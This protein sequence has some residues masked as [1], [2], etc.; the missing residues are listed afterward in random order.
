LCISECEPVHA[1]PGPG[2]DGADQ[3]T[4]WRS[5]LVERIHQD[6][7]GDLG[8]LL[9]ERDDLLDAGP[10]AGQRHAHR[11]AQGGA[12]ADEQLDERRDHRTQSGEGRGQALH[13]P[14]D[15]AVPGQAGEHLAD[16]AQDRPERRAQF[17][18]RRLADIARLQQALHEG[19]DPGRHGGEQGGG[20]AQDPVDHLDAAGGGDEPD[21]LLGDARQ[22]DG[23][24]SEPVGQLGQRRSQIA[25]GGGELANEDLR[26]GGLE[27]VEGGRHDLGGFLDAVQA[28]EHRAR[29][30]ADGQQQ[31]GHTRQGLP[32]QATDHADNLA[33]RAHDGDELGKPDHGLHDRAADGGEHRVERGQLGQQAGGRAVG[34]GKGIGQAPEGIEDAQDAVAL[35]VHVVGATPA[36][37]V[38]IVLCASQVFAGAERGAAGA[39]QAFLES[40]NVARSPVGLGAG[41]LQAGL[42]ALQVLR[43]GVGLGAH[44]G[45]FRLGAGDG[46]G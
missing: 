24:E 21:H 40:G 5:E 23:D 31:R 18:E 10:D 43:R 39:G 19:A 15:G 13:R 34:A 9:E 14:G 20:A 32:D 12:H 28:E 26:H 6:R 45:D 8:Q 16:A 38:E 42:G 37:R 3:L 7:P 35:P 25:E 30:G 4:Q 27:L 1:L 33:E 46:L 17:G 29:G 41:P 36:G 2:Q 22:R 11:V 44:A